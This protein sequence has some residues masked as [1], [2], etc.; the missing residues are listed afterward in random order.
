MSLLNK[1]FYFVVS[2]VGFVEC[3]NISVFSLEILD[4]FVLGE[5]RCIRYSLFAAAV[6]KKT[7]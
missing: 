5:E 2:V 6:V 4:F 7:S 3:P 1:S